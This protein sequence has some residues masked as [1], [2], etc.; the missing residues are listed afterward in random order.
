MKRSLKRKKRKE[1]WERVLMRRKERETILYVH[2][3]LGCCVYGSPLACFFWGLL[4]TTK[5]EKK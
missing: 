3:V 2:L 1:I 4:G 5:V